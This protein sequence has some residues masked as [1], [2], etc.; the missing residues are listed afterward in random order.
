MV[1]HFFTPLIF[2]LAL[3]LSAGDV[4]SNN[5]EL[6]DQL[7][8][9]LHKLEDNEA[10]LTARLQNLENNEGILT[11]RLHKLETK[12]EIIHPT[13]SVIFITGGSVNGTS[14][15]V[16]DLEDPSSACSRET[17]SFPDGERRGHSINT[18]DE[19]QIILCGGGRK[20]SAQY[21]CRSSQT[22]DGPWRYHGPLTSYR[23]LH[24]SVTSLGKIHLFAGMDR[25]AEMTVETLEGKESRRRG[26]LPYSMATGTC[27]VNINNTHVF[28]AG[29]LAALTKSA[30]WDS[31][32]DLWTSVADMDIPRYFHGCSVLMDE[33]KT[34]I[35]V[36]GGHDAKNSVHLSSSSIYDLS[37]NSWTAAGIM[38]HARKGG[39]LIGQYFIGGQDEKGLKRQDVEVFD[40]ASKKWTMSNFKLKNG[41][42]D[43]GAVEVDRETF[44][45]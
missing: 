24:S 14:T 21:T 13:G 43:F 39:K 31:E 17:G 30:I 5:T 27:A 18:D 34:Y 3:H 40:F 45:K 4:L 2:L 19:G 36:A 6:I 25:T 44:C 1:H 16:L 28:V 29:G 11:A 22:P 33:G 12:V 35:L 26:P 20:D 8:A 42:S 38:N 15:E 37:T 32:L 7:T 23:Y 9:R 41:R 10:Q